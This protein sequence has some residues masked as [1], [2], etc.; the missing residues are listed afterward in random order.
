[1]PPENNNVVRT[2]HPDR[3]FEDDIK[4]YD[5]EITAIK[6]N[7]QAVDGRPHPQG[8]I[9]FA[10]VLIL[11]GFYLIGFLGWLNIGWFG[12]LFIIGIGLYVIYRRR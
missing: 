5:D 2:S 12:P 8:P 6:N 3:D 11:I 4:V 9:I 1:M 10:A 7:N